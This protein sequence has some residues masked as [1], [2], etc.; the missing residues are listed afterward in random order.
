MIQELD[1]T[2]FFKGVKSDPAENTPKDMQAVR[3]MLDTMLY[4]YNKEQYRGEIY[5]FMTANMIGVNKTIMTAQDPADVFN[6]N[7]EVIINPVVLDLS[8]FMT[9]EEI[10]KEKKSLFYPDMASIA[11]EYYNEKWEKKRKLFKSLYGDIK[12]L[13]DRFEGIF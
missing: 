6:Y 9:P 5:Y 13:L 8:E 3:D 11:L 2:N 7:P 12:K 10:E 4:Y 1:K